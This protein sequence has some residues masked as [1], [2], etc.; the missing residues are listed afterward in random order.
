MDRFPGRLLYPANIRVPSERA[1]VL[2][3][4]KTCEALAGLGLDVELLYP[5]RSVSGGAG[6]AD[7]FEYYGIRHPFLLTELRCPDVF[8]QGGRLLPHHLLFVIHSVLFALAAGREIRR[9]ITGS[10]VIFTRDFFLAY[11][12]RW[13]KRPYY[14]EL[15]TLSTS[16]IGRLWERAVLRAARGVVTITNLLAEDAVSLGADREHLLVAPDGVDARNLREAPSRDEA[17][18]KLEL[19]PQQRIAVYAGQLFP[20]KG[21]DTIVEAAR[22]SR[23]WLFIVVG[24]M[25]SDV[26]ALRQRAASLDGRLRVEGFVPPS[27]IPTYLAAADVLL[28]PN[29]AGSP[30]SERHTSPLKAFEYMAAERA[31]VASDLPSLREIFRQGENALLFSP[32]DAEALL[33]TMKRLEGDPELAR[34]LAESAR[35]DAK[36]FTWDRRAVSIAHFLFPEQKES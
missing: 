11:V 27:S 12:L 2:Q 25:E 32:G 31:I 7:P 5:R 16:W 8:R 23:E 17:R 21:I 24:G 34:R 35:E 15:H 4:F 29:L 26:A 13:L 6:S 20:W 28:L 33:D 14:F 22:Q 9:R 19:A 36:S 30:I 1:H 18:R 10:D 3:I